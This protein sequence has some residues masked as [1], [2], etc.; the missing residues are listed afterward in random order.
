MDIRMTNLYQFGLKAISSL[1]RDEEGIGTLEIV[2]IAAVLI[3]VALFFKDWIL[4]FLGNLMD[5]VEGKADTIF[6]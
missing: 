1:W 2:L 4:D 5:S 3:M 6:K